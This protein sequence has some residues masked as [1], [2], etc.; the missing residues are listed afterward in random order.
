[1]L[2]PLY[3]HYPTILKGTKGLAQ[4][5]QHITLQQGQKAFMDT[6]D[7]VAY[8]PNI[9]VKQAVPIILKMFMEYAARVG[10]PQNNKHTNLYV[11]TRGHHNIRKPNHHPQIEGPWYLSSSTLLSES[12]SLAQGWNHCPHC[13]HHQSLLA[14]ATSLPTL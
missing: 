10:L 6:G 1:M 11:K 8:H 3:P 7:I 4:K 14:P 12:R 5:L 2:K 13:Q 9:L